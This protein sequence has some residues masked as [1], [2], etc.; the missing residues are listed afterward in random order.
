[1]SMIMRINLIMLDVELHQYAIITDI[2]ITD[3][4]SISKPIFVTDTI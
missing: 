1:M 4:V 3:N 2:L